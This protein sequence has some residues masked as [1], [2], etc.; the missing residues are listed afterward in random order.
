M[1]RCCAKISKFLLVLLLA[2]GWIF[3]GWPQVFNFPPKIQKAQAAIGLPAYRASGTFTAGTGAITPPYPASMLANDVCLLA[4]S[5]ENE[6][7]TLTT[8]NGFVQVPTWSPQSAGTAA[9]NPGSR[10]AVFWKLTVGGD[11]APV[12][13]D[14]GNNTEGVIHCFSGVTTSGNPWDTGAGGN[15]TA[16]ND[17]TG[18]V[19][20]STT[21]VANTLVVLIEST[22]NNATAATNCS[23][24]TNANLANILERQDNSNTAGLG[25]GSC[26]ATGEKA[27]AGAYTTTT[28]TMSVTTFKGAISLALKPLAPTFNQSAYRL[29]NNLDSTDVGTA[30]AAQDT[31]AT[32]GSTGATFRLRAFIHIGTDQ[33]PLSGQDFKLQFAAQSGTCDTAFVG[34]TYADV[35]AATV[36][37]YNNNATPADGATLIA[38]ASD[39]THG[40]DTI[41]NQ[42]YEELNNFTNSVAA[43]PAAQD[44]KWDFSL[45]DNGATANTAYCLR[46]VKSDGTVI[47]TYTVIPQI[48]TA[49][50]A[51]SQSLTFSISQNSIGFGTLLSAGPRFANIT[52][53]S[54]TEV[55]AHTLS[56]STNA[57]GG[58]IITARGATL[59][60][61]SNSSFTITAIGGTNTVSAPNTEQFGLRAGVTS[62]TGT[63]T[64]PYAAAG[65]AYAGTASTAS[66]VASGAGDGAST[67]Y[68]ARYI[69]NISAPTEA[70]SYSATLTYVATATF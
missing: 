15:D 62:G 14:S 64:A 9:T 37:A 31:A 45:K 30:L 40:A 13:A 52:G 20:G 11:A 69:A 35:T 44:G 55:E 28:V 26:M 3:S 22:S 50:T 46:A 54:G 8:A 51:P 42:T 34:E 41:V 47:N 65:F 70:G 60:H 67:I 48:T 53:G 39:P 29:F 59:T 4:V 57:T 21:T 43:I 16:A 2:T 1:P 32:L 33:D 12:V 17:T 25:G 56:A 38:N 63:V 58:Y 27:T 10:L 36:I 7:I 18:N 23:A 66:Q 49:A 19:P 68:S 61:T 5:S 24:W 6:A